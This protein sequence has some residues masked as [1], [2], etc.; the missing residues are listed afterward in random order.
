MGKQ[1]NAQ[2]IIGE[3]SKGHRNQF[4]RVSTS[5]IWDNLSHEN[6]SNRYMSNNIEN[7]ESTFIYVNTYIHI[8]IYTHKLKVSR[9]ICHFFPAE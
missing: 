8:Y 3:M 5:R 1:D 4:D 9:D 6:N 7:H 2:R